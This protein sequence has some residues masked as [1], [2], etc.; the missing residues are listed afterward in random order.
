VSSEKLASRGQVI[1]D[2]WMDDNGDGIWQ[3][4]EAA[5]PGVPLTAGNAYVDAATDKAAMRDDRRA[6][7]V[8]PGDDRY[9][10]GQPA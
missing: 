4:N 9:R 8:P 10:R 6:G 5:L 3:A 1:A 7:A 2:V